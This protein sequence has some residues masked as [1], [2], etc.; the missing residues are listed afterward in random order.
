MINNLAINLLTYNGK[1]SFI[2]EAIKAVMPYVVEIN[3]M[4][5]GSTDGT[6]EFIKREFP[7]V[8]IE[9]MGSADI[10]NKTYYLNILKNFTKSPWILRIDDDEIFPRETMEEILTL[11]CLVPTYSIPFLHY[12]DGV[13]IDP[14]A[15]KKDSFYVA[16][17]FN[18]VP[19]I[20]WVKKEEVLAYN[21]RPISSR[22][23]QLS[24]CQK[25]SNPF[26]HFGELRKNRKTNYHFH[27]RGHCGIPLGKY[28]SYL[29]T[30][31]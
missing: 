24:L 13:F 4:D 29:P 11:D 9:K 12:E 23:N 27:K 3:V 7:Q 30:K 21:N 1:S 31:N 5:N 19:N 16:R 20:S 15:H 2:K 14:K 28:G 26:L 25:I 18:N 8:Q 10:F 22:G 6:Y 17:L